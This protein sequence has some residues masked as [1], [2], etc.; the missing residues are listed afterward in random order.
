MQFAINKKYFFIF[1]LSFILCQD[2]VDSLAIKNDNSI[3]DDSW[4]LNLYM[5]GGGLVPLGQ[6][7]NNKP[8]KALAIT[9]MKVYWLNQMKESKEGEEDDI[10]DRNRS[11]WW[12]FFLHFYGIIDAYVDSHI[13]EFP[14]NIEENINK[15]E[16]E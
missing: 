10:S 3:N 11:F 9:G 2:K 12:L 5:I 6:L 4:K 8:L 7:E 16:N 15:V 1:S 14:E 13:N